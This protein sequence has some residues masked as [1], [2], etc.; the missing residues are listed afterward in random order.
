MGFVG[1][2]VIV[3][4][5]GGN[6]DS[7]PSTTTSTSETEVEA[8]SISAQQLYSEYKDNQIAAD[9]K[10]ENQ[11]LEVSGTVESI[12]KD[13]LDDM[14][15]ALNTGDIIGSVQCMLEDSQLDKAVSLVEGQSIVVQGKNSGMLMNVILRNCTIE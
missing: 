15:V 11:I 12:G 8:I 7:T 3:A 9:L 10:Y 1:F 14:Y 6:T 2:I 5:L 4:S 13:I